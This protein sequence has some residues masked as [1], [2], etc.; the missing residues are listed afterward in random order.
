[1]LV[2]SPYYKNVPESCCAT[3]IDGLTGWPTETY[4]D[5]DRC[6]NWQY[7]PPTRANGPHNDAVYY[8]VIFKYC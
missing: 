6:Q 8:S 3:L 5:L 7:G 4:R 1:M 2:A